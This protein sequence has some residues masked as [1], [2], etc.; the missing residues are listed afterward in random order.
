MRLSFLKA[1]IKALIDTLLSRFHS[2]CFVETGIGFAT[3]RALLARGAKGVLIC[4]RNEN[5]C[6]V[7]IETLKGEFPSPNHQICF[8]ACDVSTPEGRQMLLDE[9]N[10]AFG[11]ILHGLVN[12]VG[13]NVR[14]DMSQQTPVEYDSMM[15][16]NVDSAYFLCQL[17]QDLLAH[18]SS[19]MNVETTGMATSVVNV[20][21]AAGVQSSGT[22]AVYGM[23]KAAMIHFSKILACEWAKFNIRVNA[24]K[25]VSYFSASNSHSWTSHKSLYTFSSLFFHCFILQW[26]LG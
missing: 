24:G 25:L 2:F 5:D 6:K 22:G 23:S 14:K 11:G 26:L 15:K 16:T 9:T 20:A 18:T 4:A 12:N 8:C 3:A 1:R 13:R 21:S 19:S 17:F 10:T 7:A